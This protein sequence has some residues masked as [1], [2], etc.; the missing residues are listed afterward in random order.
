MRKTL[1]YSLLITLTSLWTGAVKAAEVTDELTWQGLG[2]TSSNDKYSTVSNKTFTSNAV[3]KATASSGQGKYIQLRSNKSDAGIVTT[4]SGGKVKSVTIEF[5]K[6]TTDRAITVFAKNQAYTGA[7]QLYGTTNAGSQLGKIAANAESKTLTVSGDYE[8]VAIRA[9][10]GA[11]YI[12]KIT[13][14]W[15]TG[16]DTPV[17]TRTDANLSFST[18]TASATVGEDFTPP[19]L[20]NPSNVSVYYSSSNGE[21]AT[22]SLDGEVT[23]VGAGTTTITASVYEY[24]KVYKGSASYTLTVTAM[25]T[26][27]FYAPFKGNLHDFTTEGSVTWTVSSDNDYVKAKA[28]SNRN[29][30]GWLISPVIDMTDA[31]R[32]VM[33][34]E[35]AGKFFGNMQ[36]EATLWASVDGGSWEQ[37]TIP[38]YFTNND[39]TFVKTQIDLQK[40]AGKKVR[41][42]FKYVSTTAAYGT[43][44]IKNLTI[45]NS[46]VEI[47]A[48]PTIS[49]EEQFS[50]STKVTITHEK[51]D[52]VIYYQ[53]NNDGYMEYDAPFDISETTT[54][55]AYAEWDNGES[56]TLTSDFVSKTFTKTT[57]VA[58]ISEFNAVAIGTT[59]VV[60]TLKDAKVLACGNSYCIVNDGTAGTNLYKLPSTIAVKQG[61]VLN[62]TITGT[63]AEYNGVPQ[64]K[65]VTANTLE[66]TDGTVTA[67]AAEVSELANAEMFAGLLR[68]EKVTV[69]KVDN[70][71]YIYADETQVI[72]VYNQFRLQAPAE[73]VWN[74][75]GVVGA[76]NTPQFWITKMESAEEITYTDMTVAELC[77]LT[78][79]TDNINLKFTDALVTYVKGGS[80]YIREGENAICAYNLGIDLKEGQTINGSVKVNFELYRGMHEIKANTATTASKL[81]I[82][83]AAEGATVA[84]TEATLSE[85]LEGKHAADYIVLRGVQIISEQAASSAKGL[86]GATAETTYYAA[87]EAGAKIQLFSPS[88]DITAKAND[89]KKYDIEAI[90]ASADTN[91][92]NI[93]PLAISETTA[94][95]NI[96]TDEALKQNAPI[97]NLAGQRVGESYKGIVIVNGKKIKK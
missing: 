85:L 53:L 12:D 22:V 58:N 6:S 64:M 66:V 34:F 52:A 7:D 20:S 65:D 1:L 59:G 54:V 93:T 87:D 75:E 70:N 46:E 71:F 73:G 84:P 77:G 89:G 86:N 13:I 50:T 3:Y 94:I 55:S 97:Y 21:V 40:Y 11:V 16:G 23:L 8:Y 2:L 56:Q 17:D 61:S 74:I 69:K 88:D 28:G 60:L 48:V 14:V 25:A 51:D 45:E 95:N 43:W 10:D 42:G 19:T 27:P 81:T 49:G 62:G 39:W 24:D 47:L 5:N 79:K 37:I 44:E 96:T 82:T 35:H 90:F 18:T 92:K 91:K 33:E 15:E 29:A 57:A 4:Q 68:L 63:R 76:Y 67:E 41:F 26:L 38:T 30:E 80:A 32:P 78:E 9:T 36:E 72:Q 31:T 83:D